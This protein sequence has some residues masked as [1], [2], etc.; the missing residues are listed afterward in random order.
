MYR[1]YKLF[2]YKYPDKILIEISMEL[3]EIV[4]NA[5][6]CFPCNYKYLLTYI[7]ELFNLTWGGVNMN[8]Q[9]VYALGQVTFQSSLCIPQITNITVS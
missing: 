1:G 9:K 5:I 6:N 4:W 2:Y 8:L 7:N 3:F